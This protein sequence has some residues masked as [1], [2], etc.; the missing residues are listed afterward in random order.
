LSAAAAR[1]G[2]NLSLLTAQAGHA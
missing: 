1:L 2:V